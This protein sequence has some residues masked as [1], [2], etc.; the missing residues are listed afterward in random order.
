M[1]FDIQRFPNGIDEELICILFFLNYK[2]NGI[3]LYIQVRFV[4]VFYKI[5]FKHHHVNIRFAE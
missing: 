2:I 1:G 4:A 3:I 5:L